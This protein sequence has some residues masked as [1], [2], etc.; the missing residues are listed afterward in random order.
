MLIQMLEHYDT[1]QEALE[2]DEE[3]KTNLIEKVEAIQEC[4]GEALVEGRAEFKMEM[5]D[6]SPETMT[7]L[8][9]VL[10]QEGVLQGD[11]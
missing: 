7:Q 11:V 8:V 5:S 6:L 3:F 10:V 2:K 9:D 4:L 1:F